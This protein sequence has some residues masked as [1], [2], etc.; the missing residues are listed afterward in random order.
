[1]PPFEPEDDALLD[2]LAKRVVDLRMAAPALFLLASL[3]P[4]NYVASQAMVFFQPMVS[5]F[6]DTTAYERLSRLLERREAIRALLD[7][8]E[9]REA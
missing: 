5:A 4:L 2:A 1:V 6:F 7:K 3:E 8:I 9:S